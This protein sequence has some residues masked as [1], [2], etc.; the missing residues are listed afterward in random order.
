M[1]I[2]FAH[3]YLL[4]LL[5]VIPLLIV[6][7]VMRYRKQKPALQFSNISLFKG[8][9]KTLRQRAYPLLFAL[10]MVAVG[11]II[12]ALARPQSKLS[13]QE[14]KV[15]GIDIVMAMDVSGS[16]LAEDF[17]PNRLEAA[18]KVAADFIEGR[19][20]DRMGL[21]VFS[22]EA[23][24]QVPL[25]IDHSVLLKQLHEL[26][27]GM[28][29]DGTALG[30]GLATAINRI[31]D[32]QAKSKVIILLTDGVNNQGA[33]DPQSAAEI[34]AL[35]NIRLYTIGVGTHGLAPYPFKDQF[36][37]THYQNVPVELDEQLLTNMA[38]S[39]TDGQYFRATNKSSLQKIFKQ[40]DEME[41]SKIDVTQYAQTKDEYL[42]WLILAAVALLLE[43]LLG[44]FY[45]RS[46]P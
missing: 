36:G 39:T 5:L 26:K 31:K 30:D 34:A 46:T 29:K 2:T 1:K 6:W 43:I 15:E 28:I 41:K 11:A 4:L 13:R 8:I 16:M 17:K 27:S 21:V 33:V 7:Y 38:H 20:N 3:P 22:G 25:T 45:F 10:R 19:K 42:G 44:L 24:T 40:I 14:M 18:K 35:Y 9:H 23:F 32:S 37:R 12:V